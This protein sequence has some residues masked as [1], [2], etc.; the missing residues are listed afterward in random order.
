[1][2]LQ[3]DHVGVSNAQL[4][5]EGSRLA[6]IYKSQ[7]VAEQNSGKW[8]RT[9]LVNDFL[10]AMPTSFIMHSSDW[11]SLVNIAWDLLMDPAFEALR[12]CIYTSEEEFNRFRATVVNVRAP[13]S[14]LS[15]KWAF[16]A[17]L[18]SLRSSN[19]LPMLLL[20]GCHG[21]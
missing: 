1:M 19:F 8:N 12:R 18:W 13:W 20:L 6:R 11:Q 2:Y 14:L 15:G 9:Y 16:C 21:Y 4:V 17:S 10:Q 5:A 7:S 3:V